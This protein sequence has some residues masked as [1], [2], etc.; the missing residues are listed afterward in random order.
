[1]KGKDYISAGRSLSQLLFNYVRYISRAY[2]VAR[3]VVVI[4]K[5]LVALF[6]TVICYIVILLDP[7]TNSDFLTNIIIFVF[8][9]FLI[10]FAFESYNR[11]F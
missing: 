6:T 2:R 7:N 9:S 10:S 11:S 5:I 8:S 4:S 1:M 3:T